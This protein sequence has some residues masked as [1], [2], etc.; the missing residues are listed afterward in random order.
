MVAGV[1][2]CLEL[3]LVQ[4][5]IQLVSRPRQARTGRKQAVHI[6]GVA[7]DAVCARAADTHDQADG[8][9]I[10]LRLAE[11]DGILA[12][13]NFRTADADLGGE[14][15]RPFGKQAARVVVRERAFQAVAVVAGQFV[16]AGVGIDVLFLKALIGQ[17]QAMLVGDVGVDT[18][19]IA[20]AGF[21]QRTGIAA[22]VL[23]INGVGD[24]R[25]LVKLRLV[26]EARFAGEA[27]PGGAEVV[28][29]AKIGFFITEEEEQPVF[30]DRAGQGGAPA[31]FLERGRGEIL[32][33]DSGSAQALVAEGEEGRAVEVVGTRLGHHVDQAAGEIRILDI[34]RREF[35]RRFGD[36]VERQRQ[37]IARCERRAVEAEA[38]GLGNAVHG[39][40]VGTVVAAQA[41]N[42]I[43]VAFAIKAHARVDADDVADVAVDRRECFQRIG[44]ERQARADRDLGC[45]HTRAGD[46]DHAAAARQRERQAGVALQRGGDVVDRLPF[47]PGR[48]YFDSVRAAGNQAVSGK[49]A[50]RAGGDG[51]GGAGA[52]IGDHNGCTADRGAVYVADRAFNSRRGL[53]GHDRGGDDHGGRDAGD[54]GGQVKLDLH[55]E[56]AP[57]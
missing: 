50:A 5:G 48:G 41:G 57:V 10:R 46:H 23:A 8:R 26:H 53:L 6:I 24:L 40:G 56:K 55:V 39:E 32:S 37:G 3:V 9:V 20:H 31:L 35:D 14:I 49:A 33:I 51:A 45:L 15:F 30:H 47:K 38:V 2:V 52:R 1:P 7:G 25:E 43:D 54:A 27:R 29:V 22:D 42:A 12:V 13:A 34:E 11:A 21:R 36:H 17:L 4:F 16:T 28:A 18:A 44:G 19:E